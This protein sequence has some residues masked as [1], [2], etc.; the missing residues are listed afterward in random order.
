MRVSPRD[1]SIGV[2]EL[3]LDTLVTC[4]FQAGLPTEN[5]EEV[6][7]GVWGAASWDDATLLARLGL[8]RVD[9]PA[10][11]YRVARD[12][13]FDTFARI[14]G[15]HASGALLDVGAGGPDLLERLS[16]GTRVATDILEA[17]RIAP[18]ISHV[19]Q[20]RPDALPFDDETFDTVLMT[21]MAHHLTVDDRNRLLQDAHRCLRPGGN[22]VLVEET[23]SKVSGCGTSSEPALQ[24]AAAKF[25]GMVRADQLAFLRFTDWWGNRVMKGSDDI[26]LPMT[27][28]DLEQWHALLADVGLLVTHDHLFG[29]MSGG[30][31]LAT[32][33]A[34]IVAARR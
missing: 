2:R 9:V 11:A 15:P 14:V 28:L 24:L 6:L 13:K 16:A 5:L 31:H 30:G 27:F 3:A 7:D 10:S 20:A 26:P 22:L 17:E 18:G 34:L 12:R 21:G 19:V 23:F 32:P 1:T 29:L 4:W 8:E 33:R 25:N